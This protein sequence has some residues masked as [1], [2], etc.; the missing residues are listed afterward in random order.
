[1]TAPRSWSR[2]L[3][4]VGLLAAL[5]GA[6]A[7]SGCDHA[8]EPDGPNLTDRF[9][10]F[11]IDEG[12]AANRTAFDFSTDESATFTGLFNKQVAWVLEITGQESGAVKRIEGFSRE[13]TPENARWRGGT[14]ELP[15]FK[16]ETVVAELFVPAE[17]SDTTRV[18][19]EVLQPRTYPGNVIADFEEGQTFTLTNP[20]F[21]F[22]EVGISDIVPPGQGDGFFLMR[23]TD[24]VV[25]NNFFIGL[26]T[27][28]PTEGD[29][30]E[31][32]TNI[33][34]ELYFNC[35]LRGFSEPNTIAVVELEIEG[36]G[37]PVPL[38]TDV[39]FPNL[40]IIDFEGWQLYSEPASSFG[41]FGAGITD[42]QTERITGV[43]IVLISDAANQSNPPNQ[44]A[45]G[46]DYLTFTAGG[47]LE[48]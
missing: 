40:G 5:L 37:R 7:L 8:T 45:F 15:L 44:V 39:E 2:G 11:E 13:V 31:V 26:I 1:M 21:E 34:E 9:G 47:P 23:G 25:A 19:L 16:D 14:S 4:T 20:E 18:T 41:Q 3:A 22:D 12:L 48:L 43:R 35:F 27:V 6:P 36:V 17:S 29:Y 28:R 46:I 10:P 33:A 42:E 24:D 32:P 38:G 30:F